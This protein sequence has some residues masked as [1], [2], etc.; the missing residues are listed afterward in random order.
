MSTQA[1]REQFVKQLDNILDAIRNNLSKVESKKVE[2]KSNLDK[3]NDRYV[4][5]NE[6]KRIY[7]KTL[8]DFQEVIQNKSHFLL[9]LSYLNIYFLKEC[10]KNELLQAKTQ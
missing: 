5:L 9:R 10:K 3:L 6:K 8:K 7:Y 2:A 4:Q 1:N